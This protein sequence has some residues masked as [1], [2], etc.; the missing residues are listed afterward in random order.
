MLGSESNAVNLLDHRSDK[1]S[2]TGN[3]GIIEHIFKTLGISEGYFVEFGAWDG[4]VGSNCKKLYEEG[5][6]G[7]FI[8][9]NPEKFKELSK[10]YQKIPEKRRVVACINAMVGLTGEFTFDAIMGVSARLPICPLDFDFCSIDIDGLDVEVFETFERYRPKVICIEGGQM[11]SPGH[12]R[13]GMKKAK[14]NI[15]QSLNV[16]ADVFAKKGYRPICSYQDTFFV[17]DK[18]Y[19][20]FDVSTSLM[21]LYL[22]GLSA[23]ARRIPWILRILEQN[24]LSNSILS[25]IIKKANFHAYG[26]PK[27]KK[28]AVA[29][30]VRIDKVIEDIRSR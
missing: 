13:I 7:T 9:G 26:W 14:N 28:W 12:P 10:N 17:Q 1:Y 24:G 4:I 20:K 29:E 8:E 18:Y 15:Q 6:R 22:D 21:D 19:D 27:R 25:E 11:L 16:M 5:W 23:H 2:S 3:D 30:K